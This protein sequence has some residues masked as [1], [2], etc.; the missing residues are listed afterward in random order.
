MEDMD[1]SPSAH[2]LRSGNA[3]T[4]VAQAGG[5]LHVVG[6]ARLNPAPGNE[7]PPDIPGSFGGGDRDI[8]LRRL[9]ILGAS[10]GRFVLPPV[11][12][13][14]L[15]SFFCTLLPLFFAFTI[16]ASTSALR[17]LVRTGDLQPQANG[18]EGEAN[19]HTREVTGEG[20]EREDQALAATTMRGAHFHNEGP[21]PIARFPSVRATCLD[22]L[23]TNVAMRSERDATCPRCGLVFEG[24]ELPRSPDAALPSSSNHRD[25]PIEASQPNEEEGSGGGEGEGVLEPITE[26]GA[27]I[28]EEAEPDGRVTTDVEDEDERPVALRDR[29]ASFRLHS[30]IIRCA[31]AL[32]RDLNANSEA[33]GGLRRDTDSD[34][35]AYARSVSALARLRRTESEPSASAS[36]GRS[37]PIGDTRLRRRGTS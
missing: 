4:S 16:S 19:G 17:W 10:L 34:V 6:M 21:H 23:S 27:Q 5:E 1:R 28:G 18:T 30:A 11:L 35:E 7:R 33:G 3:H 2:E 12:W 32:D 37:I 15:Q 29:H 22:C 31:E 14:L 25:N 26:A 9:S 13:A 36:S 24:A 8:P 20:G